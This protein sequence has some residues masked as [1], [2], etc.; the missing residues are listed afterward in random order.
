MKAETD[1][2]EGW[3]K[4]SKYT[5]NTNHYVRGQAMNTFV[6]IH[7]ADLLGTLSMFD[8]LIFKGYLT[9]LFPAGAFARYLSQ[10][11]VLLKEFDQYVTQATQ[12]IKVHMQQLAAEAGRPLVYLASAPTRV[13]GQTKEDRARAMAA[14]AG[15]SE[16]LVCIFS[17]LEM[18]MSFAVRGNRDQHKLEVVRQPRKCLHYYLYY[19]DP[20]WGLMHIRLQSWFPFNLQIYLNGREWLARQLDQR[21]ISYQRYD[22]KL[23]QIADLELA[24]SLCD[25]FTHRKWPRVLNALARRVNPHLP[26]LQ[27]A[28]YGGYYWVI[29]QAEYATDLFFRDPASLEAL[30]PALVE[31]AMTAFSAEDVIRFLGRKPHGNFQGEVITDR[32]RRKEGRRVKH[33]LKS[34]SLKMYDVPGLLRVETTTNNPR[35]FRVLRVV[36]TPQGRQRRWL[37]MGKGVANFW[38]FAQVGRQ[39][40]ERYLNALAHAQPK[41]KAIAE[42]DRLCHP[43]TTAD[44]RYARF[45]PVTA[46]DCDLFAAVLAGEHALNGFRNKDLQT[47]LYSAPPSSKLEQRRRSARVTRLIAKLHGHGLIAKVKDCRLY[48]VTKRGTTLMAAALVCR[49]KEFPDQVLQSA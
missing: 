5:P 40:N 11:G 44:H 15:L 37:P 34:N 2:G 39:A 38:R 9:G 35:E 22:N 16:G 1:T 45:N 32:K 21:G 46:P 18:G 43:V 7:Q 19:L 29:D 20:E 48:R 36:D 25:K 24:Q 33:S 8:R 30:F 28:G 26:T 14:E 10:Q 31:L 23:F 6:S 49:N 12:A 17:V 27:Q 47:K 13:K 3:E 42:L 41:G 4:G